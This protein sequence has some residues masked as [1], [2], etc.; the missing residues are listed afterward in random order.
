MLALAGCA[1][2]PPP[3]A[4]MNQAQAQIQSAR[5]AGAAD[6]DP[7]DF[8]FAQDKF[9][10]AQAAM[11]NRKY[12][13]AANLAEESMADASLA[14]TKALLGAARAQ[15]QQKVQA[16]G[17]LR[18]QN[19]EARAENA[20]HEAQQRAQLAQQQAAA[21]AP[22]EGG[23]AAA[24]AQPASVAPALPAQ[25]PIQQ[26]MPAPSS[27]VLSAPQDGGF[28][29]V[30]DNRGTPASGASTQGGQP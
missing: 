10:Q 25:A 1:S 12:A 4:S 6:Y 11:S 28:Q 17:A 8:G 7:V 5:E 9:Q 21:A 24:P 13:D 22:A 27:S 16:N 2:V 19:E 15:I 18:A 26:D 30:P 20:Q 14:R 29:T 23:S 3:D